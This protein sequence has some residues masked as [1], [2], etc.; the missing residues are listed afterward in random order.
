MMSE[1]SKH[2]NEQLGVFLNVKQQKW[3]KLKTLK[4]GI[5]KFSS[6]SFLYNVIFSQILMSFK[7]LKIFY[8]LL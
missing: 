8:V 7:F 2:L 1:L 6:K 5:F 3:N 4:K